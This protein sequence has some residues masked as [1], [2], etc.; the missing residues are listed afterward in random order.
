VIDFVDN[1]LVIFAKQIY[2]A[3]VIDKHAIGVRTLPDKWDL[4]IYNAVTEIK[5]QDRKENC[6]NHFRFN[7][8]QRQLFLH[9]KLFH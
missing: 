9:C 6:H 2:M 1:Y 4:Q 7:Q 3:F 5:F 8:R